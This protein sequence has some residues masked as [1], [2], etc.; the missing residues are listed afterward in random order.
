MLQGTKNAN[1]VLTFKDIH[2][3]TS[4]SYPVCNVIGSFRLWNKLSCSPFPLTFPIMLAEVANSLPTVKCLSLQHR[5]H[6]YYFSSYLI[7]C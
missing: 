6:Y 4:L 5:R 3:L 7:T 1:L 2:T